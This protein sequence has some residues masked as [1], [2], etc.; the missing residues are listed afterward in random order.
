MDYIN[1]GLCMPVCACTHLYMKRQRPGKCVQRPT[2]TLYSLY[3][4]AESEWLL[5]ANLHSVEMSCN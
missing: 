3:M 1:T 4:I 5:Y 2:A